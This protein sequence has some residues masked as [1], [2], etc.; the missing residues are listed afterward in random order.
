MNSFTAMPG[1]HRNNDVTRW[2]QGEINLVVNSEPEGLAQS[3]DRVHGGSVCAI[4]LS[5][6]VMM[7]MAQATPSFA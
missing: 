4:G 5:D 3:F 6:V 7:A 2:R 1:R